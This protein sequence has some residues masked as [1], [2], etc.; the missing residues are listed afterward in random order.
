MTFW[1]RAWTVV[2][3][4]VCCK[5]AVVSMCAAGNLNRLL[6]MCQ[7]KRRGG[8][9]RNRQ[10]SAN[11]CRKPFKVR[12]FQLFCNERVKWFFYDVNVE[13]V[14]SKWILFPLSILST[15][16][17]WVKDFRFNSWFMSI[18]ESKNIGTLWAFR[19][20]T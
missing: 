2:V 6:G 8:E 16:L 5:L 13:I 12:L 10:L 11:V 17:L 7:R 4:G 14:I 19:A 1:I 18:L 15:E 9:G 20:L 3:V